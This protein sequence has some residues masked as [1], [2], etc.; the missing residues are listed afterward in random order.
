MLLFHQQKSGKTI[1]I[2]IPNIYFANASKFKYLGK[3]KIPFSKIRTHLILGML[4]QFS[5]ETLVSCLVSNSVN[6]KSKKLQCYPF[7]MDAKQYI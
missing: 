3:T 4:Q 6:I 2:K 5:S 1:I 7:Y